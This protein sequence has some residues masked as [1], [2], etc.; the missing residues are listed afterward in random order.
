M[1]FIMTTRWHW[2]SRSSN[3]WAVLSQMGKPQSWQT[4]HF[5][6][7]FTFISRSNL[8]SHTRFLSSKPSQT[9]LTL[10]GFRRGSR[11]LISPTTVS[12]TSAL[13]SS[14][15]NRHQTTLTKQSSPPNDSYPYNS[16][17]P[18]LYSAQSS[19]TTPPSSAQSASLLSRKIWA[20]TRFSG[21]VIGATFSGSERR[22]WC[23]AFGCFIFIGGWR[24]VVV[25]CG[26]G[27][28]LARWA[29][30][31]GTLIGIIGWR[32]F[33]GRGF[34]VRSGRFIIRCWRSLGSCT[35]C[36]SFG[37]LIVF[38]ASVSFQSI[39]FLTS[40]PLEAS[41]HCSDSFDSSDSQK[42]HDHS[43]V[44]FLKTALFWISVLHWLFFP[45]LPQRECLS[46]CPHRSLS[47]QTIIIC[48][49]TVQ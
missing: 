40:F 18:P 28:V 47:P 49:F 22:G 7:Q 46:T 8:W 44:Q 4:L 19:S 33:L 41:A 24:L 43:H 16:Q 2:M 37:N 27:E 20:S 6:T 48:S 17:S 13:G 9:A 12:L 30:F 1:T 34:G 21:A 36:A 23:Y 38:I 35:S 15:T 11:N 14:S 31:M 26:S 45:P 42:M 32:I 10:L 39:A 29:G 25:G 3:R 5:W